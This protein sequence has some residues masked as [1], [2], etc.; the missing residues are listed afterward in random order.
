MDAV[1]SSTTHMKM[2][3]Y[4]EHYGQPCQLQGI[5]ECHHH[6]G[7]FGV[8]QILVFVCKH[9]AL[10]LYLNLHIAHA[11]ETCC[12]GVVSCMTQSECAH[13][14]PALCLNLHIPHANETC[15][16]GVVSCMSVSVCSS[17]ESSHAMPQTRAMPFALIVT[18]GYRHPSSTASALCAQTLLPSVDSVVR[19]T[20]SG[21]VQ[22]QNT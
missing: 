2:A 9:L 14:V 12:E 18:R 20:P 22:V 7:I 4:L 3:R 10:A 6:S 5:V 16:E 13:H 19:N 11:D 15:C 17:S 1:K 8:H 21:S